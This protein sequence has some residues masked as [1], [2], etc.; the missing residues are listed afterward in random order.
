MNE[1]V[2]TI[3]PPQETISLRIVKP[4]YF[5]NHLT[6]LLRFV[7]GALQGE[8]LTPGMPLKP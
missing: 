2:R 1:N 7:L 6:P 3:L 8:I 5:S 4:F